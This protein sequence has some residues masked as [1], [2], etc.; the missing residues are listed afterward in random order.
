MTAPTARRDRASVRGGPGPRAR[1]W[2]ADVDVAV[3]QVRADLDVPVLA[4]ECR[5]EG[6]EPGAVLVVVEQALVRRVEDDGEGLLAEAGLRGDVD[7]GGGIRRGG[8]GAAAAECP[9][10]EARGRGPRRT[11]RWRSDTGL[12]IIVSTA[13][14]SAFRRSRCSARALS[15]FM[16]LTWRSQRH[17]RSGP[18]QALCARRA[19]SAGLS[20]AGSAGCDRHAAHLRHSITTSDSDYT[21]CGGGFSLGAAE[22]LV[23]RR[24]MAPPARIATAQ[25]AP[26]RAFR[27]WDV[28][29]RERAGRTV[30]PLMR[31]KSLRMTFR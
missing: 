2:R 21:D 24:R 30:S 14:L 26:W 4:E 17:G 6:H 3:Q 31:T 12:V 10:K 7:E 25:S 20:A 11:V 23:C 9:P 27:V 15:S 19:A 16:L 28:S 18:L 22:L 1:L 29:A 8:G 5:L 13:S